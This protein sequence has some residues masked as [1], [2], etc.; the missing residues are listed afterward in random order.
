M[1]KLAPLIA[2]VVAVPATA[3]DKPSDFRY[4]APVS[5][6]SEASHYRI[7]VPMQ[8]YRG[9]GRRDL[10]DMRIF[11]AAGEPVPYAFAARN[12]QRPP[13]IEQA[14][15]MFPLY[16]D[17]SKGL[18]ASSL[19]VDRDARGTVLNVSV[20]ERSVGPRRRLLGYVLDA[21]ETKLP[22]DAITLAWHAREGFSGQAQVEGTEDFKRWYSVAVNAPILSL[23]HAGARLERNR[24]ELG[25]A[26]ARYL[27]LAFTGVP[28]DF[29]LKEVALELRAEAP[30]PTREWLALPG[31][32]GKES[33]EWLFD[34]AGHFPVDRVRLHLPQLNTVA[35]VQLL[36][37]ERVDDAWRT[38]GSAISYRL[39]GEAG[40]V[41]N[42][43]IV[44]MT[45][46]ARY[47]QLKVEQK[48]GGLG[49]GDVRFQIGWLPHQIVF[50]A[51]GGQPFVFAYGNEKAK[52]GA[53]PLS[54]VL[55]QRPDGESAVVPSATVGQFTGSAPLPP[56]PF[57]EP[58]R[59]L[60]HVAQQRDVRKWAL[61]GTL[62]AGVLLLVWMAMRLLRDLR[63]PSQR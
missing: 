40:D 30:Q 59:F 14:V 7:S 58:L 6:Q 17:E 41:V 18:A 62:I 36:T 45:N 16:G 11:N 55:P 46:S 50:A 48:G 31:T 23:Q 26:H 27:R 43:D 42:P 22:K 32:A 5:A 33:G 37:R 12:L 19:R 60:E 15:R 53:L 61:W 10:G 57:A 8:T 28:S 49:K 56:S 35:Q 39:A 54:A 25:G 1:K 29:V 63:R 24:V 4:S 20:S 21:G 47:W 9:A 2:L 52:P 13:A 34:S 38:I 3:Q 51:R 44:V